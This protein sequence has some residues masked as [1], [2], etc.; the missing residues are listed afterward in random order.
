MSALCIHVANVISVAIGMVLTF[1][2]TQIPCDYKTQ[3]RML[4]IIRRVFPKRH[5]E[6]Q[7]HDLAHHILRCGVEKENRTGE[8][9]ISVMGYMMRFNLRGWKLPLLT[10][11]KVSFDLISKELVMFIKGITDNKWLQDQKCS[12]WNGNSSREYFDK[13]GWPDREVGEL[14]QIY[15]WQWRHWGAEY[16]TCHDDYTGKGIDQL[17]KVI[18]SLKNNPNDRRII[19]SAWNLKDIPNMALPPCHVMAQ[20]YVANGE[21]SCEVYQR[22]CDLFL[23]APFNYASYAAL[24]MLL[25]HMTG[26]EPGELIH[27]TGDT[28]IYKNH[29]D[30]IKKQ[31]A[32]TPYP[33]PTLKI[34]GNFKTVQ[35]LDS[36]LDH[37]SFEIHDYQHHPSI[38]APMAS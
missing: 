31:L 19:L 24:T 15:G 28:H 17:A 11:K 16:K 10:T 36:N 22:S 20:F 13:M 35:D 37:K 27:V 21:L 30:A 2:I 12:I 33:F 26:L 23:G 29:V 8:N 25:C 6:Y 32:R 5:E 38:S 7:Y 18:D 14:G 4:S 1:I 9:A 34:V 3:R